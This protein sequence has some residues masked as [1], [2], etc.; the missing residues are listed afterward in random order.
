MPRT[1]NCH[2]LR[3]TAGSQWIVAGVDLLTLSRRLGARLRILHDGCLRTHADRAT[4]ACGRGARPLDRVIGPR[5]APEWP[6]LSHPNGRGRRKALMN[7]GAPKGVRTPVSTL[8]GCCKGGPPIPSCIAEYQNVPVHMAISTSGPS[9]VPRRYVQYHP[10]WPQHGPKCP[11]PIHAGSVTSGDQLY[12]FR[13][14][15]HVRA[16]GGL[17]TTPARQSPT[18]ARAAAPAFCLY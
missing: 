10:T 15:T 1:A 13:E 2:S 11:Y 12:R 4:G 9:A 14:R 3:H 16:A 17:G 5:M 8:K 18:H 7:V 6:H